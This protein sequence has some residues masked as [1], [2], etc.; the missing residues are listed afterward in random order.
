M[1]EELL[2]KVEDAA[3]IRVENRGDCELLSEL[4]LVETDEFVSYNTLRRLFGLAA[5][6]KPRRRTLDVLAQYAGFEGYSHFCSAEPSLNAW[7]QRAELSQLLA[8]P[9]GTALLR[10]FEEK[11]PTPS[12]LEW[13]L[14]TV[15]ELFLAGRDAELCALLDAGFCA[16]DDYPYSYQIHFANSMGALLGNAELA[17]RW[18]LLCH[19]VFV[20]AVFLRLVDYS[21]LN[22]Y[23]GRWADELY[24][25]DVSPEARVF[26]ACLR[27]LRARMNREPLPELDL[28]SLWVQPCPPA[29]LGRMFTVHVMRERPPAFDELWAQFKPL[30]GDA[31]RDMTTF[32]EPRTFALVTGD[33][34]LARWLLVQVEVQEYALRQFQRHELQ[35]HYLLTAMVQLFNGQRLE[36]AQTMRQFRESE[37]RRPSFR[38]FLLFP[39]RRIQAELAG[40]A[41]VFPD[42]LRS[43]TLQLGHAALDEPFWHRFFDADGR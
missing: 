34:D 14:T 39:I 20:E 6:G 35:V 22:G 1:I 15:R 16:I 21:A 9:E 25:R 23:Y 31:E 11:P 30:W 42:E 17:G 32:I 8:N 43:I 12:K 2:L 19:P 5:G 40:T 37:L 28:A 36:A 38:D 24:V 29:L 27:Q 7:R 33:R 4:I 18:A 41:E 13:I 10:W 26:L 3:R